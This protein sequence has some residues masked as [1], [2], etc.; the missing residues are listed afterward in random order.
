MSAF[1]SNASAACVAFVQLRAAVA[2]A[3]T[4]GDRFLCAGHAAFELRADF[5]QH[6][7]GGTTRLIARGGR[8][9]GWQQAGPQRIEI[10]G[11]RIF[12]LAC[13]I[14]AAEQLR[15]FARDEGKRNR[16][17]ETARGQRAADDARAALRGVSTGRAITLGR[18]IGVDGTLSRP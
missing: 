8:E 1:A 12:D 7:F 11:N 6:Q 14:A 13:V 9:Q 5:E 4:G 10:G 18:D 3:D 2:H 15:M 16:L 17:V